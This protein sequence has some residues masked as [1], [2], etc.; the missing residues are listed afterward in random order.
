MLCQLQLE[1]V[2]T[3]QAEYRIAEGI[4]GNSVS[5]LVGQR[6]SSS[7]ACQVGG[8]IVLVAEVA[9]V[10]EAL[11]L[12]GQLYGAAIDAVVDGVVL[13]RRILNIVAVHIGEGTRE[14]SIPI[15]ETVC[16]VD[17]LADLVFLEQ[18]GIALTVNLLHLP[19]YGRQL[20]QILAGS[21][22]GCN[23]HALTCRLH[24]CLVATIASVLE[25]LLALFL[26]AVGVIE[27]QP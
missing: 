11:L 12:I 16:Q 17:D 21:C 1:V 3:L 4:G 6:H 27:Y 25:D 5:T 20:Q 15:C 24:V 9:E 18:R 23:L 14:G 7:V 26:V 8:D 13:Q 22:I 10:V 2:F 19:A